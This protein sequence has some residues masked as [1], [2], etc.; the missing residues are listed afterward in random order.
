MATKKKMLQAAAGQAGGGG[1]DIDEVFNTYLYT[2]TEASTQTITNGI[3]LAGEGG[4]V[5][6]KARDGSIN[7]VLM[8]S[9]QGVGKFLNSNQTYAQQTNSDGMK[10][11]DSDGFTFGNQTGVGWS[12]D[13]VYWTFRKAPKFFTMVTWSGNSTMGRTISHDLGADVGFILIK[14]VDKVDAW[15]ALHKDSNMLVL[16]QTTAE[17]T[18]ATTAD[19]F[20]DGTNIVR[21]TSTEF[22]IGSDGGINGTGYNYVAYIFAH[23]D[24]DGEFGA[25]GD[26]DIIKCGSYTGN[27]S[28]DGPE[29][30]LGFEP[31]F[32]IL[33]R[34]SGTE[35]WLMF[36]NM[37]GMVVG[38]IDPDL[39]PNQSQLEGA[40]LNYLE[41]NATGFKLID[42]NN[43]S[44]GSGDTY[45]YMAIR[46]GPMAVPESGTE[47]FHIQ[48]QSNGDTYS[49]GFPND[50]ILLNKTGGSSA[51]TYVGSR[52]AGNNKY[53]VTSSTAAEGSSTDLWSFDLQDSFDQ[54]ASTAAPWVGWHWKRAP[55]FFDA[56]AY[57]GNGTAGRTVSHNLGVAPE[58]VWVKCRDLTKD[59]MVS[60]SVLPS[61]KFLRLNGNNSILNYGA[62]WRVDSDAVELTI[63]SQDQVNGSGNTYIAYLFA[64]LP[65]ISKVGSFTGNGGSQTI[66]CGF[67][68]GARFVLIKR[69]SATSNWLVFDT[70]RG[71]VSGTDPY[72]FLDITDAENAYGAFDE[73]DPHP[74]GF[75]F[76]YNPAGFAL[77][78]SGSKLI[79]YAIA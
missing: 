18:N 5:W 49:V 71:I 50:L 37:R 60:H 56:V 10:S 25:D 35:D 30:D 21:P 41:P 12:N 33:K 67:T 46:R 29:I 7:H 4:L 47:V 75:T 27:G 44:N 48:S 59:W 13:H 19:Y 28:T 14:A 55:G 22:T 64:S 9:E 20:G 42:P 3:D 73:I 70:E 38:G 43:R 58:M 79:F 45:I 53:L 69:V 66:D 11:F 36:D 61:G 78:G 76:N 68:S 63:G 26:A 1:L 39:R 24:G 74:S 32:V 65:G 77:N 72:L 6:A 23:N 52:L 62:N 57:T 54:G 40:F 17:Y 16:N 8:D 31:Q 15:Y 2:G 51:N 34:S